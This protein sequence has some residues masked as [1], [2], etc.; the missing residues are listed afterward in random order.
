MPDMIQ[1]FK[2]HPAGKRTI[3]DHSNHFVVFT[4]QVTRHGHAHSRRQG[5]AAVPG[6]P[7]IML[8]L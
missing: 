4:L 8:T 2:C 5:G 3:T 7:D 6:L 1:R